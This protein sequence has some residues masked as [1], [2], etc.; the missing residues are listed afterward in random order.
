MVRSCPKLWH[1]LGGELEAHPDW[2]EL[3]NEHRN[4]AQMITKFLSVDSYKASAY[5]ADEIEAMVNSDPN[6]IL[7]GKYIDGE[8]TEDEQKKVEELL[9]EHQSYLDAYTGVKTSTKR[10]CL[11]LIGATSPPMLMQKSKT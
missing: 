6:L 4:T 1:C 8:A 2:N 5:A 10:D 7:I 3:L 9:D 11:M